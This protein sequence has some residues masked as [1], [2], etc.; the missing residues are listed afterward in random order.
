MEPFADKSQHVPSLGGIARVFGTVGSFTFGGGSATIA[1]L[2]RE[3]VE[4]ERWLGRDRFSLCYA[5][6]RMTPGTNLLAFC[7]AAGVSIRGTFGA[8]A[9]LLAASVPCSALAVALTIG[10]TGLGRT[11]WFQPFLNGV[12]AAAIGSLGTTAWILLRPLLKRSLRVRTT[13]LLLLALTLNLAMNVSAITVLAVSA[14]AGW[15][16]REDSA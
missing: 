1:A 10:F 13:T 16:W 4:H 11:A 2:E 8:L 5:L 9:A 3:I 14:L 15:F 7:V 6:S 12:I